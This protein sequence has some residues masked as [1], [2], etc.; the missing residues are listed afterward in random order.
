MSFAWHE[1]H[2][3]LMQSSCTLGFQRD[4]DAI[5]RGSNPVARYC[6]TTALL[7]ALHRGSDAPDQKNQLLI[8]LVEI[9]KSDNSARDCALTVMLL[10]LWPGLD[11][12]RRRSIWRKLG[13]RDEIVSDILART[14]ETIRGLD[15]DRVNRIAATVLRN[16]ERDMIRARQRETA[17]QSMVSDTD[18]DQIAGDHDPHDPALTYERLHVDMSRLIGADAALVIRVAVEGFSQAQVGVEL[19][20]SEAATRKRYQR[21]TRKLRDALPGFL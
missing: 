10:A 19:G 3:H 11:A 13:A 8:G 12:I 20:L 4:F 21:A 14:T 18:P 17:R 9:A 7:D 1:I 16:V 6:D 2:D 5:R 15:L